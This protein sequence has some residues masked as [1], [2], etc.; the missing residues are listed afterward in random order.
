MARWSTAF[1]YTDIE[2]FTNH[3]QTVEPQTWQYKAQQVYLVKGHGHHREP[4]DRTYWLIHGWRPDS[5]E[6]KYWISNAPANTPVDVMLKVAFSRARAEHCF[7]IA[8]DELGM[9][10]YEGRSY[11]GL[12]RHLTLVLLMMLFAAEQAQKLR[13]EKKSQANRPAHQHA[14][15]ATDY[16]ADHPRLESR[17]PA[18]AY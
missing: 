17:L 7:R 15:P 18:M 1:I 9:S 16:R 12:M 4:T 8:S 10:H 2:T 3:R 13:G 5:G 14:G 6:H 11:V